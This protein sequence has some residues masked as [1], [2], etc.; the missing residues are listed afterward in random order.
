MQVILFS[1]LVSFK[2]ELMHFLFVPVV[3]YITDYYSKTESGTTAELK[4]ALKD[5]KS[6]Q[7]SVREMMHHLKR[8]YQSKRQIGRLALLE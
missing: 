8:A 6:Q 7:M 4:L 1:I 5:A 3:T 2:L